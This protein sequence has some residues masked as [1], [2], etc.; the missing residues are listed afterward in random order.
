MSALDDL[1]EYCYAL[2]EKRAIEQ[3]IERIGGTGAPTG[4]RPM[5]DGAPRTNDHAAATR[6]QQDGLEALLERKMAELEQK[7]MKGERALDLI[8]YARARVIMRQFYVLRK[9][10]ACIA[11][12]LLISKKTVQRIRVAAERDLEAIESA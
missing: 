4:I 11:D 8:D 2:Q 5:G 1:K 12:D 3:Q 7:V 6:Q 9:S 10:D